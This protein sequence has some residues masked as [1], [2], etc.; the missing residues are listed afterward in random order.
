VIRID[1]S[2]VKAMLVAP[3]L[4]PQ[5][6]RGTRGVAV[7]PLRTPSFGNPIGWLSGLRIFWVTLARRVLGRGGLTYLGVSAPP[8]WKRC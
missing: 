1:A 2:A 6:R 8:H 3:P 7:A 4:S 5:R